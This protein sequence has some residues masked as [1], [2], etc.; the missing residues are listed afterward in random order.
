MLTKLLTQEAIKKINIELG[1]QRSI[2]PGRVL[3][4]GQRSSNTQGMVP[5]TTYQSY[6]LP[7]STTTLTSITS[8]N[9]PLTTSTVD[10]A[11][12]TPQ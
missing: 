6:Q 8:T 4:L 1:L 10:L 11:I 9:Q 3:D 7:S 5:K 12:T 2:K